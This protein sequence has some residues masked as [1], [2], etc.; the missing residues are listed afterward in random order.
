[1]CHYTDL[2]LLL[3]VES[4]E[5][6]GRIWVVVESTDDHLV[7]PLRILLKRA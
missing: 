6:R 2:L 1:M 5:A 7:D 4:T 3:V